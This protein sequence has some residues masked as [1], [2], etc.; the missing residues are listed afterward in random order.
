MG[1]LGHRLWLATSVFQSAVI[2]FWCATY[3]VWLLALIRYHK[4]LVRN[5]EP[6][7]SGSHETF[8]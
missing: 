5:I 1:V 8:L 4:V 6:Y 3:D 2:R 7:D